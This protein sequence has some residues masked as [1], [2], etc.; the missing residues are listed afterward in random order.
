MRQT[1]H[2]VLNRCSSQQQAVAALETEQ[3]L[4]SATRRVLDILRFVKDHVL[5]L[6]ALEVLLVLR[7][8]FASVSTMIRLVV[9]QTYQLVARNEDMERRVLVVRDLLL[10]PELAQRSPI[11]HITPIR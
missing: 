4:P 7:D 9:C 6:H 8:L 11:F 1:L 10:G 2:V 3:R 5:P